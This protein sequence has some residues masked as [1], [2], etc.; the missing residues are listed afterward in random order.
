[1][2]FDIKRVDWKVI[3]LRRGLVQRF[4][5]GILVGVYPTISQAIMAC[6]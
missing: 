3:R 4:V 6:D 2:E 1:M 5:G